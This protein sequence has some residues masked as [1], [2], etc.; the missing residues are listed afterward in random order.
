M[1]HLPCFICWTD[2]RNGSF[3]QWKFQLL[4]LFGITIL[5]HY[6]ADGTFQCWGF[7]TASRWEMLLRSSVSFSL[8]V[9]IQF[10]AADE[11]D[12]IGGN[13][14][15]AVFSVAP[16]RAPRAVYGGA[17]RGA[18]KK[19]KKKRRAKEHRAAAATSSVLG[20]DEDDAWAA[21]L[22]G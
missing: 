2:S 17:R 8:C 6:R 18:I 10:S 16:A 12:A 13:I 21:M 14:G 7:C 5:P 9:R 4:R 19:K 22:A 11:D 15:D 1:L 20:V 3:A